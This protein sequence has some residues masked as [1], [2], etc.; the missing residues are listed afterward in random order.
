MTADPDALAARMIEAA[1]RAVC[2]ESGYDPDDGCNTASNW[3]GFKVQARAALAAALKA[4][5]MEAA[6][7]HHS[8]FAL[9]FD[10][11]RTFNPGAPQFQDQSNVA[12]MLNAL[13]GIADAE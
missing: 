11:K 9:V 5:G 1:A 7:L 13:A 4:A 12:A 6:V 10:A 3:Q 2:A 8:A